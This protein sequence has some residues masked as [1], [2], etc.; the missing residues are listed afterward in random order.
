MQFTLR[1]RILA[2]FVIALV[3]FVGVLVYGL[4]KVQGIEAELGR[5]QEVW[6]PLSKGITELRYFNRGIEVRGTAF[7]ELFLDRSRW[8]R[9]M[10]RGYEATVEALRPFRRA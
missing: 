2:A 1:A 9:L 8:P 10:R 6:L 5:V 3:A 4:V 7:Y